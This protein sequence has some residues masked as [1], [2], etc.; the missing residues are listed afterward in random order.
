MQPVCGLQGATNY[1]AVF[2]DV[3]CAAQ[4]GRSSFRYRSLYGFGVRKKPCGWL[5]LSVYHPV[6]AFLLLI[7]VGAVEALS[8]T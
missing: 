6:I 7:L 4:I 2:F 5:L 8:G 3:A 1:V